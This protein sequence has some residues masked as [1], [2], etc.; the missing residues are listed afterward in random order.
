M[1][2][3]EIRPAVSAD[4]IELISLDHTCRSN[5]VWQMDRSFDD[6]QF[7]IS[8]RE[9]RL[10]RPIQVVYPR[11]VELLENE[12]QQAPG[13]MV[14]FHNGMHVGY[15]RL[16]E[17]LEIQSAVIKDLVVDNAMRRKGI[18]TAL[19]MAAQNWA[20]KRANRRLTL[21]IPPKSYPAIKLAFKMG[22]EFTGYND[23]YYPNRDIALFFSKYLK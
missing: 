6:G 4:I 7:V 18:G 1:P 9:I 14:A 20:I 22:F 13:L 17:V 8:F 21:E 3:I 16:I 23:A 12:W 2:R 10:P 5:Y 19:V 11:Q 15:I